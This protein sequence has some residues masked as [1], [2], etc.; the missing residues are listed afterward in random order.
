MHLR[1]S[2]QFGDLILIFKQDS[3]ATNHW[4]Q[5]TSTKNLGIYIDLF[6]SPDYL[7]TI[8]LFQAHD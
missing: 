2:N 1:L 5:R 3:V 7:I 4:G 8:N 6:L